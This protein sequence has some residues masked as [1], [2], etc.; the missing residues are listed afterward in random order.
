M[1]RRLSF[2]VA[3]IIFV[4]CMVIAATLIVRRPETARQAVPSRAPFVTTD[5]VMSGEGPIPIHGGGTVRPY[6]EVNVTAEISGRIVWV[7]PTFQSGG[8]VSSG[9]VLF[10]IDDADYLGRVDRARANVV[11]QEVELM[12]V[13]AESN[14][15]KT[16]FEKWK[17]EGNTGQPSP[18]ALWEPQIT[19]AQAALNRDQAELTEAELHLS[20][21]VIYSPFTAAVLSESVTVGQFVAAG[22][23]VGRL[24]SI[25]TVEVVVP[26]PDESAALIPGLWGL[27]PSAQNRRSSTRVIAK[28]GEQYYSWAGYVDRAE[29]ALKKQTRTIEVVIRVPNPFTAGLALNTEDFTQ[30]SSTPPLLIGKFVNVEI[31]GM[32]PDQYFRIRRS[33]LKP[34]AEVWVVRNDVLNRVPVQVLQRSEDEVFLTGPLEKGQQVVVSGIQAAIDG[35]AVR[36]QL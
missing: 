16:Q 23:S 14:I 10:R 24:Y 33:A 27:R 6:A 13:T 35:M 3:G 9:E 5:S 25:D 28:Y 1:S 17:N 31:D 12:R 8:L 2:L 15:A 22:Q 32:I 21:V 30:S 36:T 11:A 7:N 19:A 34:D 26:L 18:L 20:R 29:A 4:G